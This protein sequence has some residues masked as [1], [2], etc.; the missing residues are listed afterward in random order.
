MRET[1]LE[2]LRDL[3]KAVQG[4]EENDNLLRREQMKRFIRLA[5]TSGLTRR[6]QEIMQMIYVDGMTQ[7]QV[8]DALGLGES[9]V[10][11]RKHRAIERMKRLAQYM[12]N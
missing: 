12:A 1:Q 11:A 4:V 3:L 9:A 6:Q 5:L 2:G 7:R 8:A 10:S